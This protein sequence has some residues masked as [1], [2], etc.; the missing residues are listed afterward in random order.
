MK[1]KII[2]SNSYSPRTGHNFAA[3]VFKLFVDAEVLV[4]HRSETRIAPLL[5]AY[6]KIY[7]K[8]I[9]GKKDK[10]F[11]DHLFINDLRNK[12]IAKSNKEFIIIKNTSFVGVEQVKRV[13]PDDIQ[14]LLIRDP[15]SVLK[16]LFK[17]MALNKKGVKNKLKRIGLFLGVYPLYYSYVLAKKQLKNLPDLSNFLIIRYEDLVLKDDETLQIL[18]ALFKSEKSVEV[19]K[20]EIDNIN[21]IN[22]SYTNETGAK[23]IWDAKKKTSKFNPL[24]RK[25][26]NFLIR[27]ALKI[28]SYPLRKKLGYV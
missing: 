11:F 12:I 20:S 25:G 15:L 28:G 23:Q 1:K 18:S 14:I 27:S 24:K 16:S 3:E 2:F 22:S 5:D 26:H 7:D 19:I 17:G 8:H 21:V 10:D 6:Y 13:F 4:H 9:Y